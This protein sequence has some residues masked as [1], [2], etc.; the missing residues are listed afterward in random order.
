MVLPE[1][2][3]KVKNVV[4]AESEREPLAGARL[5]YDRPPEYLKEQQAFYIG[6]WVDEQPH[7][8][9]SIYF[10]SGAYFEGQLHQG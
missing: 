2:K 9:G 6:S 1:L 5:S 8:K 10:Q 3:E 4:Q 7:G